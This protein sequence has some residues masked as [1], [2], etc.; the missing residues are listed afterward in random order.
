MPDDKDN[1]ITLASTTEVDDSVLQ[2]ALGNDESKARVKPWDHGSLNQFTDSHSADGQVQVLSYEHPRSS[3]VRAEQ[4]LA[5]AERELVAL[6]IP[7]DEVEA[8]IQ[9]ESAVEQPPLPQP[10]SEQPRSEHVAQPIQQLG[11]VPAS[12]VNELV[13]QQVSFREH[14]GRLAAAMQNAE[15]AAAMSQIDPNNVNTVFHPQVAT[16]IA[17]QVNSPVVTWYLASQPALAEQISSM[18]VS[19]AIGE[20]S[21]LS[22]WL[23]VQTQQPQNASVRRNAPQATPAPI[24]PVGGG[25]GSAPKQSFVSPDTMDYASFRRWR[26]ET[27]SHRR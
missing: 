11:M 4:A 7:S 20:V 1:V 24:K 16:V 2:D 3:R 8:P 14:E 18:P 21:K 13:E 10:R 6:S 19:R 15:F 9:A 17:S 5:K 12:Q 27:G 23:Q 25:G 22:A 26:E